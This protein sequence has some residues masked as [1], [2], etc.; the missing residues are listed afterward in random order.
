MEQ[1]NF[2]NPS[3]FLPRFSIKYALMENGIDFKSARV[4]ARLSQ[5]Q[6]ARLLG[7]HQATLSRFESGK[8]FLSSEKKLLYVGI[9]AQRE[10]QTLPQ[11]EVTGP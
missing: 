10:A 8:G 11:E 3:C 1:K 7:I 6:V 9:L 2:S 5:A 4:H